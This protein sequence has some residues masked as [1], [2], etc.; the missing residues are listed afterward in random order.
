MLRMSENRVA[1]YHSNT[2]IRLEA[3][4]Q[5]R[6]GPGEV[7]LRVHAS[8]VCGSDV[9]EWYRKPK[10]PIVL[11]HEVSGSIEAVGPGVQAF[12]VGDRVVATHHVP[13]F[14]CQYCRSGRETACET[15][16]QTSFDPGGFA[17]LIR[18]PAVNVERGMLKL[19]D[20]VSS[21]AGSM[22]EPLGCV[23]R[24]HRKMGLC[25]GQSVLIIGG[26]VSGCLH[27]L[28]SRVFGAGSVFIS[29]PKARRRALVAALGADLVFDSASDVTAQVR[30]ELGHGAD[31]VIV[32]TGAA[33]AIAQALEVVDRGGTV[34]FFAPHGPGGS[35]GIPFDELFWRHEVTLTSSYGASLFDLMLALELISDGALDVEQLITHRLP[36][37][38]TQKAFE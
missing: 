24:G 26:G 14:K 4:P 37:R 10:A 16:R 9:M 15:L 18:V 19:P 28:A 8:G 38:D 12:E 3:R 23:V 21:D 20:N 25:Q 22:V 6:V 13:C 34:L 36:L 27:L 5:P 1:V 35:V 29:E 11:G 31:R 7:L 33:P 17:E 32:C 2:D 30:R